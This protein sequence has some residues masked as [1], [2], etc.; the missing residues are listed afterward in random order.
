MGD[1]VELVAEV[2]GVQNYHNVVSISRWP[3][4][5]PRAPTKM[6]IPGFPQAEVAS[7]ITFA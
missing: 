5:A 6:K 1:S 7:S 4:V 3:M 2:V